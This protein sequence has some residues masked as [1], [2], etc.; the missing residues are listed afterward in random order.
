MGF[1][2]TISCVTGRRA[3]RAA[4]RG[5]II[6][7]VAQVGFEPTASLVL[8]QSGLPVGYRA[9]CPDEESN[10]ESRA[11]NAARRCPSRAA[12]S[13]GIPGHSVVVPDGVEPSFPVCKTGVVAVGPRDC[14]WTHWES[15][16]DFKRAELVSSCWT[17]SPKQRKLDHRCA[18]VPDSNPQVEDATGC[19]QDNFLIRPDDFR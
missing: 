14:K 17:M 15:H 12:F 1:E 19:F 4:P 6:F 2:P 16:P 3:L 18:A 10:L 13:V 8:S 7:Q 5:R 9:I 11:T